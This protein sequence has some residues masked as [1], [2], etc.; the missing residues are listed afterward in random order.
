M[1]IDR[2]TLLKET[3]VRDG[4]GERPTFDIA[5]VTRDK[6]RKNR[7]ARHKRMRNVTRCGASHSLIEHDQ[8]SVRP[9][10]GGHPVPIH[11][12]LITHYNGQPVV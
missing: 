2:L 10:D 8:I 11:I 9:L 3:D 4:N 6:S 12:A 7:Y 5:F 1:P